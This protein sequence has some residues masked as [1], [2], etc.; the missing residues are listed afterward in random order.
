[1]HAERTNYRAQFL[2]RVAEVLA[3]R[4]AQRDVSHAEASQAQ[5]AAE[6]EEIQLGTQLRST[7]KQH[8]NRISVRAMTRY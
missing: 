1:M 6:I 4:E 7:Q 5:R 3:Q 2:A 8:L